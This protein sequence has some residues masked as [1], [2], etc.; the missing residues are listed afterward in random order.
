[1]RDSSP[2]QWQLPDAN[3]LN[4]FSAVCLRNLLRMLGISYLGRFRSLRTKLKIR[5]ANKVELCLLEWGGHFPGDNIQLGRT[6]VCQ[7]DLQTAIGFTKFSLM[8]IT[9]LMAAG[10]YF[11]GFANALNNLKVML[12]RYSIDY[13]LANFPCQTFGLTTGSHLFLSSTRYSLVWVTRRLKNKKT[14]IFGIGSHVPRI[15]NFSPVAQKM[16]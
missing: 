16:T 3:F 14:S 4:H 8:D 9:L 5:K 13:Q 11:S 6:T 12:W 7:N 1:M 10:I 15:S 2:H